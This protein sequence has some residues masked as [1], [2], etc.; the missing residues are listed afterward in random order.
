MQQNIKLRPAEFQDAEK[1]RDILNLYAQEQLLLERSV[2]DIRSYIEN[3]I[4]A[5]DEQKAVLGCCALRDFGNRLYEVRSLAVVSES[6]GKGIGSLM[7]KYFIDKLKAQGNCRLFALTYRAGLFNRLG[8]HMVEK[9]LFPEKIWSDCLACPKRD[10][11][12]EV[13]VMLELS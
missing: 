9:D 8:F 12:D 11:C 6:A 4:V 13:A 3:F 5:E 7:V 2:E 1:I 10:H